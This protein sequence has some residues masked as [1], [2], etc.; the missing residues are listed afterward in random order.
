MSES[1]KTGILQSLSQG[2]EVLRLLAISDP[3]RNMEL[4]EQTG[5]SPPTISRIVKT[6]IQAG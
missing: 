4:A 2:I 3:Q 1:A 6:L 5:L